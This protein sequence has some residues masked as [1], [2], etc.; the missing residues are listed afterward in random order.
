MTKILQNGFPAVQH[1][2]AHIFVRHSEC[3]VPLEDVMTLILPVGA[4]VQV[5][6]YYGLSMDSAEKTAVTNILNGC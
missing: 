6:Y 5:K 4:W 2:N 3:A 1:I